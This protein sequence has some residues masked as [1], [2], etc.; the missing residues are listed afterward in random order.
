MSYGIHS[1]R[2]S[3]GEGRREEKEFNYILT[4]KHF[5][6][7]TNLDQKHIEGN[8]GKISYIDLI[9]VYFFI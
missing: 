4:T 8:F 9:I 2:W 5:K 6:T 7:K 3:I 1:G